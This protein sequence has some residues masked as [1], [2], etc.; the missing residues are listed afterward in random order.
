M[1]LRIHAYQARNLE[2]ADMS[3][4]S[5]AYLVVRFC[6]ATCK[7]KVIEDHIDPKWYE[8]LYLGVNV[9]VPLRYAPRVYC[10]IYDEDTIL[11]DQLLGRFSITPENIWKVLS[12][13]DHEEYNAPQPRPQWYRLEDAEHKA[14]A[15]E[16]LCAFELIDAFESN[17]FRK[18]RIHPP[19]RM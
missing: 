4:L 5:D 14:V 16:V 6:G 17:Y 2:N 15:G 7:T 1:Q 18:P 12:N 19:C 13:D 10:E 8:S 11:K 3:G 9:P